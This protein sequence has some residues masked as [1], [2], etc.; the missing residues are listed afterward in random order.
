MTHDHPAQTSRR[1]LLGLGAACAG[2]ALVAM[3]APADAATPVAVAETA[4]TQPDRQGLVC[5]PALPIATDYDALRKERMATVSPEMRAIYGQ[6]EA[7]PPLRQIGLDAVRA[8]ERVPANAVVPEGVIARTIDIP[9]PAGPIP[10]RIW[11]PQGARKPVG[12]Y[13]STHGGGWNFG[14]GLEYHDAEEGQHVLDWG[15]AVVR[16]DYR[17][18]PEHKFPAAIDDCYATLRYLGRHG[19]Q[20]GLDPNR[21][22]VGGGCAGANIGTV[23]AMMARDAGDVV[24]KIQFLWS[25]AVDMR[26]NDRAHL[27]FADGYGLRLDDADFVIT[28]YLAKREDAYDWHASP[29][30][31]PTLKG[32]PPALVWVGEWEIL[33]DETMAY[34]NRMR[35]AGVEVHLIEGE[36]QGHGF[37]YLY[38]DTSYATKTKPRIDAIMRSYIGPEAR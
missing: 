35:D 25:P 31:A 12:V 30:L 24:P 20:L 21:I 3:R 19:R 32:A 13:L 4:A 15:C 23:I 2:S 8:A 9:G 11:M 28:N 34:V 16:P 37:I 14:G 17:I 26:N 10:T 5:T 29:L 36:G 18:A 27:E 7:T 33:H 1:A 22:G 6:V 38:P